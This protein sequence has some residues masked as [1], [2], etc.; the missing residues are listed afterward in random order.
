VRLP[1]TALSA[2]APGQDLQQAL[3]SGLGR[4]LSKPIDLPNAHRVAAA[5]AGRTTGME[6]AAARPGA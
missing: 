1:V 5:L 6:S 3:A 2:C 4:E